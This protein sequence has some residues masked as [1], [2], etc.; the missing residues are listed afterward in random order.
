MRFLGSAPEEL[1]WLQCLASVNPAFGLALPPTLWHGGED[2]VNSFP[3]VGRKH[4]G[5]VL[6][7][8]RHSP[9]ILRVTVCQQCV[10]NLIA[11]VCSEWEA[12]LPYKKQR[13]G[14]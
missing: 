9:G 14:T 13:F 5:N 3:I 12:G 1:S 10:Q 2:P 8:A 4:P 6:E 7:D 11:S